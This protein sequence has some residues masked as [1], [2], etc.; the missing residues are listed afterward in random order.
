MIK[1][2]RILFVLTLVF[3][4]VF[5]IGCSNN[6]TLPTNAQVT[7]KN[8]QARTIDGPEFDKFTYGDRGYSDV[9]ERNPYIVLD[10][11]ISEIILKINLINPD[12][13]NIKYLKIES[14]DKDAKILIDN[15]YEKISEVNQI[16]WDSQSTTENTFRLKLQSEESDNEIIINEIVYENENKTYNSALN[17]RNVMVVIKEKYATIDVYKNTVNGSYVS[18]YYN[19]YEPDTIYGSQK[20]HREVFLGTEFYYFTEFSYSCKSFSDEC[21]NYVD[22][23]FNGYYINE[24]V[25]YLTSDYRVDDNVCF[26]TPDSYI[27]KVAIHIRGRNCHYLQY[28][29]VDKTSIKIN[30]DKEY[31]NIID[32]KL[33]LYFSF[34]NYNDVDVSTIDGYLYEANSEFPE[35]KGNYITKVKFEYIDDHYEVIDY[36]DTLTVGDT[37]LE[38]NKIYYLE[39][40]DLN[41]PTYSELHRLDEVVLFQINNLNVTENYSGYGLALN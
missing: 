39:I 38:N 7:L 19:Y 16:Q 30:D 1:I 8:V 32:D 15:E 34:E 35:T 21:Y 31:E 3:I 28:F 6:D 33:N 11:G 29:D 4:C 13:L 20:V 27:V 26:L 40:V 23:S 17:N 14:T 12:N 22:Q 9:Y 5:M 25:C 41:E 18:F 24:N 36:Y 10:L 37:V 2:K